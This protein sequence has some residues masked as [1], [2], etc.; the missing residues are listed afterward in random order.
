[1]LV[2]N[3]YLNSLSVS[4]PLCRL[5]W[6]S[7]RLGS[8]ERMTAPISSGITALFSLENQSFYCLA[9]VCFSVACLMLS[10]WRIILVW[11]PFN[12][13]LFGFH[14]SSVTHSSRIS[15][16][17]IGILHE[18]SWSYQSWSWLTTW[19]NQCSAF[20]MNFSITANNDNLTL[21]RN[22]LTLAAHKTF[23]KR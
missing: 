2:I 14:N 10:L 13:H 3:L 15:Q 23:L 6:P 18:F 21:F 7:L 11:P 1:M 8:V 20:Y 4:P 16:S 17:L 19:T 9:P 22:T 5:I 12:L